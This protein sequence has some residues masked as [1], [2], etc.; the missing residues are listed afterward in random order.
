MLCKRRGFLPISSE[1]VSG[2]AV[3]APAIA[4]QPATMSSAKAG[5]HLK[6]PTP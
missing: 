4:A 2:V 1:L 5:E 6:E 3:T